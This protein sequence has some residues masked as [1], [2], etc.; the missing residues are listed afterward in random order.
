MRVAQTIILC[1]VFHAGAGRSFCEPQKDSTKCVTVKYVMNFLRNSKKNANTFPQTQLMTSIR[2]QGFCGRPT[3]AEFEDIRRAGAV[4]EVLSLIDE[5]TGV[6]P[7]APPIVGPPAPPPPPKVGHLRVLCQ[8]V[9]CIVT[10]NGKL[11]G[12]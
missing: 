2:E 5:R 11:L 7:S 9:D 10:L 3:E 12:N 6:G 8:P 4:S 1:L